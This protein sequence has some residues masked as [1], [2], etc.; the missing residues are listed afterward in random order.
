MLV[1]EK[2]PPTAGRALKSQDRGHR[3]QDESKMN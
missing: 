2:P 1:V 3:I